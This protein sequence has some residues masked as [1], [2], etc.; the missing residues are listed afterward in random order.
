MSNSRHP[1]APD[2]AVQAQWDLLSDLENS[3]AHA[4]P[5]ADVDARLAICRL[6]SEVRARVHAPRELAVEVGRA[7]VEM[8]A[9][10]Q[11]AESAKEDAVRLAERAL[12]ENTALR[13]QIEEYEID[14]LQERIEAL[15]DD[16]TYYRGQLVQ[17]QRQSEKTALALRQTQ[18]EIAGLQQTVADLNRI[19]VEQQG[20]LNEMQE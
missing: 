10:W 1:P 19:I 17:A 6:L 15:V 12:V 3:A 14:P 5:S 18:G 13:R 2:P 4:F 8:R 16:C 20:Q 9:S 11:R 7:L